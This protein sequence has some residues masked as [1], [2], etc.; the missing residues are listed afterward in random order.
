MSFAADC[1]ERLSEGKDPANVAL[2]AALA[3]PASRV[4]SCP[5]ARAPRHSPRRRPSG[6]RAPS[7]ARGAA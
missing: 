1:L 7:L 5:A 6:A 4:P 3:G 2:P